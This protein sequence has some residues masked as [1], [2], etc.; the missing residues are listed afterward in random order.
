MHFYTSEDIF[1]SHLFPISRYKSSL[2]DVVPQNVKLEG[3]EKLT[4]S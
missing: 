3:Q 4:S 2:D 1:V